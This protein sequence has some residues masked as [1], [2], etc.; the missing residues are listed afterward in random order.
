MP[1]RE[2]AELML[3]HRVTHLVVVDPGALR[4]VGILSSLDLAGVLAWGGS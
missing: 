2:A 1:L 3:T 4:P